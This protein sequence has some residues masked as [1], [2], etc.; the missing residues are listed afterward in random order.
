MKTTKT[1][2]TIF[3]SLLCLSAFSQVGNVKRTYHWFFGDYA[4]LDFSSGEP[5]ED[6]LGQMM[7]YAGCAAISDT[8]G[9]LL[10]YTDGIIDVWNKNHQVMENGINFNV[11]SYP[12]TPW[13]SSVIVPKPGSDNIYYIFYIQGEWGKSGLGGFY[14]AIVDMSYNS[15]LGKV[16]SKGNLLF[17]THSEAIGAVHHRNGEDVWIMGHEYC[18]DNFYAYLLTK[19]G[20]TDTVVTTIGN[21]AETPVGAYGLRFSPNGKKMATNEY[22]DIMD[23]TTF[24]ELDTLYLFDFNNQTG[25]LSNPILLPDTMILSYCF[26]PDNTKLYSFVYNYQNAVNIYSNYTGP[27]FYLYQYDISH[28]NQYD[29]IQSKNIVLSGDLSNDW[30]FSDMQIGPDNKIYASRT[31][32]DSL[33]V[34]SNP[35]EYGL[36]CNAVTGG[37]HL[38]NVCYTTLPNFITSY[39]NTDTTAFTK[40]NPNKVI[41]KQK[42][43]AYPNP[44]STE[45]IIDTENK[46]IEQYNMIDSKGSVVS[47]NNYKLYKSDN[48]YVLINKNMK[49]GLFFFNGTFTNKEVFSIQL[50]IN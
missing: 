47:E 45:T 42:Y 39:F 7:V 48:A 37:I 6:T 18:T 43:D 25:I 26:S 28:N 50:I 14:Y 1:I 38:S 3:I 34:V 36:A 11:E 46:E 33:G 44:F 17:H 10:M 21:F 49:G 35:N 19:F 15:G 31:F 23:D 4:G 30:E 29:I 8:A 32:L 22:W 20:I 5:V 12:G 40:I 2:L 24:T 41:E 27:W 16:I 13:Q 9:N